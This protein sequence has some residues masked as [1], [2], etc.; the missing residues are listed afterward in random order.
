MKHHHHRTHLHAI[1]A[2]IGLMIISQ[3]AHAQAQKAPDAA[4]DTVVVTGI[5]ASI[6]KSIDTKRQADTNVEVIS[7]EDVGKMPDKNVADALSRLPGVNVQYGGANAMDEAER[8]AIRGTAPNLNLVTLNGHALSAGDWHVGDQQAANQVSSRSVGFGLLPSQLIGQTI[9]YKTQ[10]ADIT[11]GGLA[12]SVDVILRK[13][14]DFKNQINGELSLGAVYAD[15]P[16]KTD[17]QGSGIIAWKN[18]AKTFGIMVQAFKEDRT[19]RRDGMETLGYTNGITPAQAGAQTNLIGLRM[20]NTL[21]ATLFEGVRQRT[22]GYLSMQF[23]PNDRI[24]ATLS[25]FTSKMKAENY[26]SS[27]YS[28]AANLLGA[29]WQIQ[30]AVVNG[31]TITSAKIVR[32]ANAPATQQVVGMAFEHFLRQGATS[33]SD[34]LD[35]DVGY[36]A[37]DKLKFRARAGTTKGNGD[38]PSQPSIFTA[39][40]NPNMQFSATP[41][42][43]AD[44]TMLDSATGKPIDLSNMA[45][46][47]LLS[48]AGAAVVAKDKED[49]LHLDGDLDL[50]PGLLQTLKFGLRSSKHTHTVDNYAARYYAQ[51]DANGNPLAP[52]AYGTVVTGG[53]LLPFPTPTP[54]ALY[55]SDYASALDA[56]YPR[57]AF[58]FDTNQLQAFADKYLYWDPVK[59]KNWG[60]SYGVKEKNN[61]LYLMGDFEMGKVSGNAGLRYV[62]T[63]VDTVAYQLLPSGTAAGQCSP[64]AACSVPGAITGSRVGSY[65]AQPTSITHTSLLPSLNLRWDIEPKLVGRFAISKSMGRPNY[66]EMAAAV[67]LDNIRGTGTTG[68]PY[69]KPV[70]STNVDASMAWYFAPRAYVSGGV[71]SADLKNYVKPRTSTLTFIDTSTGLSRDYTVSTR[72]GINARLRGFE[73]ATEVPVGAGFGVGGNY[74]Y[75]DTKDADGQP[76]MGASK[77]TYNLVGFFE[78]DKFSARMAWNFRSDYAYATIGNGSGVPTKDAA[79]NVTAYNG[80]HFFKGYGALSLSLSY[81]IDERMSISLDANNL[82]N[83]VRHT[84]QLTENAPTNWYVSGRQYYL[85]LRMKM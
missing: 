73:V 84:Y 11:E 51:D 59:S 34:F 5:R 63:T 45:N 42:R 25:A 2:A 30:D 36:K 12:G 65:V 35:L 47:K 62:R 49:F 83:P 31:D 61:A 7:A 1:S 80:L 46:W 6:Q 78:N 16:G 28:I 21:N 64:M 82:N 74:T 15:L 72:D 75:V 50:G 56:T 9:V 79:G 77:N 40:I 67:S 17:P 85:N 32:P 60:A 22:G 70:E 39:L 54:P 29:G 68:N 48:G 33:T 41:G 27:A 4:A 23:K 58:R 19:L 43:P 57:N 10:R 69:L 24:D 81:K 13:P 71:F 20:P 26:N 53:T 14:L 18:D 76:M 66:N 52:A 8:V 44:W 3:G 55:P 38:T 37:S